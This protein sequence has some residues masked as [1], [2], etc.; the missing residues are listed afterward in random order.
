[1][2][3][4]QI[5]E[6]K[7]TKREVKFPCGMIS[8]RILLKKDAMGYTLTRTDIPKGNWRHWH[9]KNH[10]ETCYCIS[11]KALLHD[12]KTGII[13]NINPGY[14]YVLNQNDNHKFK[15]LENTVLICIFTPPLTGEEIHNSNGSYSI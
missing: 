10:L 1:M 11:G 3:V 4:I 14:I 9:Y 2:K 5:D 7:D 12:I 8:N 13:Y 6:L 15:A